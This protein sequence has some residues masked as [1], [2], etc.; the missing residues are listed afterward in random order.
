MFANLRNLQT[1]V[2]PS[3]VTTIGKEAFLYCAALTSVTIPNSVTRIDGWAFCA[4]SSL[5]S[6]TIPSNVT[7]ISQYAF[8]SC[9]KLT[10]VHVKSLTPPTLYTASP[11][12]DLPSG[13][14]KLYVPSGKK[15]AYQSSAWGNYFTAANIIEE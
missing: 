7:S 13:T 4:C 6:V 10:E 12:F 2:L 5:M 8:G 1:L 15:S 14:K 11:V 3:G 9:S